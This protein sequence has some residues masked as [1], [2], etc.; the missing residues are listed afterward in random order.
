MAN[1]KC[2]L[3]GKTMRNVRRN[4]KYCYECNKKKWHRSEK[5]HYGMKIKHK[6]PDKINPNYGDFS[7]CKTCIYRGVFTQSC[8]Y[9]FIVGHRRP[10]EPSPNCTV[11]KKGRARAWGRP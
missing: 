8:D 9:Y 10:S 4:R 6:P 1:K 5:I 2:E 11:Y 7:Q 3:C